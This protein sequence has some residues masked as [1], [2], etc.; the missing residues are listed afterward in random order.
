VNSRGT[1]SRIV[2]EP[3]KRAGQ[4]CIRALRITVWDALSWVAADM[5][6]QGS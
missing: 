4:P 5:T 2:I 1:S 3:G 6:E